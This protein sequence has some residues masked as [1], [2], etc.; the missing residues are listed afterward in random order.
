MGR[1]KEKKANGI[2]VRLYIVKKGLCKATIVLGVFC[3]R[4]ESGEWVRRDASVCLMR[5]GDSDKDRIYTWRFGRA[6]ALCETHALGAP[7]RITVQENC[8]G[9]AKQLCNS[10]DAARVKRGEEK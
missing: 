7:I 8:G 3:G 10:D 6:L 2:K 1:T 9:R 5:K 4:M